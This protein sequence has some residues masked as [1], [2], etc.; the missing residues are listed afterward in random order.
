MEALSLSAAS[1][2]QPSSGPSCRSRSRLRGICLARREDLDLP[3]AGVSLLELAEHRRHTEHLR[4][5][6]LGSCVR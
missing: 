1:T 4:N 3:T 5:E 2:Y 6:V